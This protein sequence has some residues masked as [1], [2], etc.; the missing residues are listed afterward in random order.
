MPAASLVVSEMTIADYGEVFALWQATENVGLSDAD[1]REGMEAY[2]ARNAG[3]SLIARHEGLFVGAVLCG[4]DG[5]RG[6]LHHLAVAP[7][8]RLRG[9]AR[10]LIDRCLA[11]LAS[12]GIQKCHAWVYAENRAGL[13][14]W[15]RTG[16]A[17]R[18]ELQVVTR[19]IV[20]AN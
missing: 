9:L 6:Y 17:S 4:H 13:E 8:L 10:E 19:S 2:L 15:K 1:S 14:F 5:R 20:A 12:V 16:W 11:G 3:L 7:E 18:L